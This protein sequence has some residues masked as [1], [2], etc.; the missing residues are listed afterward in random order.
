MTM[1]EMLKENSSQSKILNG[2]I[3]ER[4]PDGSIS[5]IYTVKNGERNGS[6]VSF[7]PNGN[8]KAKMTYKDGEIDGT[9]RL[10]NENGKLKQQDTFSKGIKN[11][12]Y[13]IYD[14]NLAVVE[15]GINRY[16]K[17]FF[18]DRRTTNKMGETIHIFGEM[19]SD[20][21]MHNQVVCGGRLVAEGKL[22]DPTKFKG[23]YTKDDFRDGEFKTYFTDEHLKPEQVKEAGCLKN[24]VLDGEYYKT[25][26]VYKQTAKGMVLTDK[27]YATTAQYKDGHKQS[28][29]TELSKELQPVNAVESPIIPRRETKKPQFQ[30]KV[31]REQ[32]PPPII[33]EICTVISNIGKGVES[34][35]SDIANKTF[36]FAKMVAKKFTDSR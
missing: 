18:Y 28:E 21:E 36:D 19:G 2:E 20:G 4:Y 25:T 23:E 34:I 30:S 27:V 10:Y 12:D 15:V 33:P 1:Q 14:D 5:A 35:G 8:P 13:T 32:A 11:G 22:K 7:Y 31:S 17:K 9:R 3:T 26:R 16:D 24:G 6:Y 29:T